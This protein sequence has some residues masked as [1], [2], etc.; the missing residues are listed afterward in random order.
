MGARLFCVMTAILEIAERTAPRYTSYPTA[1]LFTPIINGETYKAWLNELEHET[2]SLYFHV[3]YCKSICLYCGCHTFATRKP[4]PVLEYA[5]TLINEIIL[6]AKNTKAKK[7]TSIAWGGG[8]PNILSPETFLEM[9]ETAKAHFDFDLSEHAVEIDPRLLT[10]AQI[11]AFVKAGVNRVSLGV[12]DMNAH[13]QKA[14]GRVQDTALIH[15]AMKKLRAAGIEEINLDLIYGLPLQTLEDIQKSVKIAASLNPNRLAIFGYAHVPW[16]KKRQRLINTEDLP[17]TKLRYEQ[18][19]EIKAILEEYGYVAIGFDHYARADDP[20]AIAAQN[21]T[22]K[23]SFQ[24]YSCETADAIIGM[25]CSSI[26]T[27]PQGYVQN[28]PEPNAWARAINN[29]E[30]AII[31]GVKTSSHD[32]EIRE[33]IDRLLSDF[34]IDL[35][36]YNGEFSAALGKLQ[37]ES[38]LGLVEIHGSQIKLT[39]FGKPFVRLIAAC[40]DEYIEK[41]AKHSKV[42]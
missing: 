28:N 29:N 26:S 35:K 38:E 21:K 41:A 3:P 20:L 14:I 24:G 18:A 16:F 1:P 42:I 37:A 17:D 6:T 4:E 27:M 34:E 23:R 25:G 11:E 5:E 33:I 40:F 13:V 10:D 12:Q 36:D 15:S 8:T 30:F 2:L 9:I 7:V 22:L 31:R 19:L 39:E 32:K